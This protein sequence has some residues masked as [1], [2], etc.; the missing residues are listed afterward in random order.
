MTVLPG[1]ST[2][3]PANTCSAAP[4]RLNTIEPTRLISVAWGGALRGLR[5]AVIDG[6][7]GDAA[8]EGFGAM[9]AAKLCVAADGP[10]AIP[11]TAT[12]TAPEDG[13][14]IAAGAV[15][16]GVV[17]GRAAAG[18]LVVLEACWTV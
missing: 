8:A 13:W 6:G 10:V 7:H 16:L 11:P 12:A 3:D 18:E 2:G 14:G 9:A 5:A 4:T 17:F 15:S 1:G